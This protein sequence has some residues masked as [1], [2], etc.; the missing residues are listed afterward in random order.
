[1]AWPTFSKKNSCILAAFAWLLATSNGYDAA[2]CD[3]GEDGECLSSFDDTVVSAC[4]PFSSLY[5]NGGSAQAYR[6]NVALS[7]EVCKAEIADNHRYKPASWPL[8]RRNMRRGS[9]PKLEVTLKIQSCDASGRDG[10]CQCRSIPRDVVRDAGSVVEIW[11]AKPDGRYSSMRPTM[12]DS[13]DCRAQIP[14]GDTDVVE[15]STV[16]PGSTGA[17][18]GLGPGGWEF[19]P[20][21][22][23]TIHFL[24]RAKGHSPLLIDL[25]MLINSKTLE[26]QGF[27][28]GDFRG[29]AWLKDSNPSEA[30]VTIR[31][32]KP[33]V[34]E[35]SIAL[36]VDIFLPVSHMD[37]PDFCP[38]RMYGAPSS[39]FLEP[40]SFCAASFLD[41]F[42]L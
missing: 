23:P 32:W 37:E 17:L 4:D 1:M 36:E 10:H 40:M 13:D 31:S 39:F 41:F 20:Y 35:N 7:N 33:N 21:G 27:S 34:S 22:P 12:P 30:P 19:F 15:F 11:Q 25:P 2:T 24:V 6:P 14:L 18:G 16:A 29:V 42:A 3:A 38:S 28:V 5:A 8:T 26:P 9:A